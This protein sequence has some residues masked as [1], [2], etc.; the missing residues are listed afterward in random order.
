MLYIRPW[1]ERQSCIVTCSSCS[2]AH[3]DSEFSGIKFVLGM[4]S[5]QMRILYTAGFKLNVAEYAKEHG[6]RIAEMRFVTPRTE[7]KLR[8]W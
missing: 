8:E 6:N 7:K 2:V 4:C 5:K 1:R 3:T